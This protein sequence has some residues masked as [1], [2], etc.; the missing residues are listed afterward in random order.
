[1]P[2]KRECKRTSDSACSSGQRYP[3]DTKCGVYMED[4]VY[5]RRRPKCVPKLY[6]RKKKKS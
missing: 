2:K 3:A 6:K 5:Q 4:V 1:M